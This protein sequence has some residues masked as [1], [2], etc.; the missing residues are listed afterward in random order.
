M[1]ILMVSNRSIYQSKKHLKVLLFLVTMIVCFLPLGGEAQNG[2]KDLSAHEYTMFKDIALS[3]SNYFYILM[4]QI[5]NKSTPKDSLDYFFKEADRLFHDS[6]VMQIKQRSGKVYGK[7]IMEYLKRLS[8]LNY[9]ELKIEVFSAYFVRDLHYVKTSRVGNS[10]IT[11]YEGII[12][13]EQHF[14]GKRGGEVIYS[15]YSTKA[16]RVHVLVTDSDTGR[17]FDVLLGDIQVLAIS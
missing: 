8:R 6:A 11:E 2:I 3:K 17:S 1:K 9:T 12:A 10:T 14:E 13:F 7:P 16:M 5:A 15:D 4:N